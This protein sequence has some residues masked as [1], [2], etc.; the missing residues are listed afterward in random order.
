M[1]SFPEDFTPDF[2]PASAGKRLYRAEFEKKLESFRQNWQKGRRCIFTAEE[3]KNVVLVCEYIDK[4][5]DI[6]TEG[7]TLI[8]EYWE[9][10]AGSP[11]TVDPNNFRIQVYVVNDVQFNRDVLD[12][13]SM[14]R[15]MLVKQLSDENN[16]SRRGRVVYNLY[17]QAVETVK[18]ELIQRGWAVNVIRKWG[19]IPCNK[20]N[21]VFEVCRPDARSTSNTMP[22]PPPTATMTYNP[23]PATI[24]T[25][26][27]VMPVTFNKQPSVAPWDKTKK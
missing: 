13:A 15:A 19:D 17:N 2:D 26:N 8:V 11:E 5:R 23:V 22:T 16:T 25:Y 12:N 21:L 7:N 1:D 3:A 27:P 24:P 18:G 20:G 14:M 4:M 10:M 9:G 6:V